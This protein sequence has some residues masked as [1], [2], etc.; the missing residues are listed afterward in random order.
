MQLPEWMTDEEEYDPP[1]DGER[2]IGRSLMKLLGTLSRLRLTFPDNN[3]S[4]NAFVKLFYTLLFIVL[5]ACSV[6]MFFTY[7]MLAGILVRICLLPA[8]KVKSIVLPAFAGALIAAI[9]LIPAALLGSETTLLTVSLKVLFS[10]LMV[11]V[12]A[13]TTGTNKLT[14]GLRVFLVP[15]IMIFTLDITLKYIVLLGDVMSDTLTALRLR[16][17]GKNRQKKNA[18]SGIMGCTFLRSREL[19]GEMH[20]AMICRGFEGEY[21][22]PLKIRINRYDVTALALTAAVIFIFIYLQLAMR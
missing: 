17:I 21:R 11:N 18:M 10:A 8:N 20:Q 1:R 6:N 9:F 4:A 16:S 14:E 13:A 5:T 15:N 2:F 22:K 12:L 3:K 7:I 19:A